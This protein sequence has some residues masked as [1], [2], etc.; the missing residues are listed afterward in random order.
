MATKQKIERTLVLLKPDAIQRSLAGEVISRLE[1]CGLK[2]V[3]CKLTRIDEAQAK[4]HYFDVAERRGQ[5]VLDMLVS[6]MTSGP[7]LAMCFEGVDAVENVRRLVGAT[8]PKSAAPGTIRGDFA[9]ASYAH[10]DATGRPIQNLVHASGNS[11]EAKYEISIWFSTNDFVE[12]T[13]SS[14]IFV[15]G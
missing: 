15:Q 12:Y 13:L 1:R 14:E 3:A 8:E 6:F 9:H 10:S 7:I 4:K 5:H 11:E 2:I